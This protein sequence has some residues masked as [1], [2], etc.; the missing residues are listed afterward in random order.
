MRP[1]CPL[2][3]R[4]DRQTANRGAHPGVPYRARL[5]LP[6]L[7][8]EIQNDIIVTQIAT[9]DQADKAGLVEP[10]VRVGP[11][12][13]RLVTA[14][15]NQPAGAEGSF[16]VPDPS[17]ASDIDGIAIL[18]RLSAAPGTVLGVIDTGAVTWTLANGSARQ[19]L[20]HQTEVNADGRLRAVSPVPDEAWPPILC[21][22]T[23][24]KLAY[25]GD[26][27]Q[28]GSSWTTDW[29]STNAVQR[30]GLFGCSGGHYDD[31]AVRDRHLEAGAERW[32]SCSAGSR[33][34]G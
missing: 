18:R 30:V 25:R 21:A 14:A 5:V 23:V 3:L 22:A 27:A 33:A 29:V 32:R 11:W 10:G 24:T 31:A 6:Q 2:S 12:R 7:E 19:G 16:A 9:I 28:P 1:P 13:N 8:R 17:P 34:P 4:P 26:P 15:A 20:L